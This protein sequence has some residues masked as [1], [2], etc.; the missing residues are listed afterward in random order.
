MTKSFQFSL[1]KVLDVREIEEDMKTIELKKAQMTLQKEQQVLDGL[2]HEKDQV[3]QE[4]GKEKRNGRLMN[5]SRLQQCMDY[6]SQ[7]SS[8]IGAQEKLIHSH[9]R[10]VE[11]NHNELLNAV[12]DK[13]IVEQLRKKDLLNYSKKNRRKEQTKENEVALRISQKNKISAAKVL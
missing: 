5:S 10:I 12:K 13:K 11:K 8:Q 6:I 3:L 9:E 4:H 2:H 7:I 1:Q